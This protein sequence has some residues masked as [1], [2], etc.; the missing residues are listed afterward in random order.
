MD[1]LANSFLYVIYVQM[2]VSYFIIK[3]TVAPFERA[4]DIHKENPLE[5]DELCKYFFS[6]LKS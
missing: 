1:S 5:F 4:C 6:G 2:K 3:D